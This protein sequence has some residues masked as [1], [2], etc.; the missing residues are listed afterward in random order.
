MPR[1]HRHHRRRIAQQNARRPNTLQ[2]V[3]GAAL[4]VYFLRPSVADILALLGILV[5]GGLMAFAYRVQRQYNNDRAAQLENRPSSPP[6]IEWDDEED[7]NVA[8]ISL[9]GHYAL[10]DDG[11]LVELSDNR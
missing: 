7:E 11:E 10:G 5:L 4:A 1:S 2:V 9:S 3:F 8:F 6:D